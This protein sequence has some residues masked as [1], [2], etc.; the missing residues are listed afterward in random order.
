MQVRLLVMIP[1]A[2]TLAACP[3][4][5]EEE[6]TP[7]TLGEASQAVEESSL[8]SQAAAI[9]TNTVEITT[10]FTL[11][12]A[13]EEA[14]A[15][16]KTFIESQLPCAEITL[17]KAKLTVQYGKK[18]G[19]CTYRGQTYSGT[20]SVEVRKTAPGEVEVSHAWVDVS[21]QRVKVNGAA[22]VT[23]SA[24]DKSRRVVH[25]LTWTRLLDGRQGKGTG[26][27]TQRP[28]EGGV[29]EGIKVDGVRGWEGAR[30]KW[31]LAIRGVE[32]RWVDPMPQAGS[33]TLVAPSGRAMT[34][35]FTRLDADT[36][37]AQVASGQRSFTFKV[38]AAGDVGGGS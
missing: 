17:E 27:R 10:S 1:L 28:L 11:G 13:V 26:D 19:Q 34:M 31:D 37:Q 38:N 7:M 23:W 30:G 22:T 6:E 35:T 21:N 18:P 24:A 16:I 33:Y 5:Q 20:H 14:A 2:L 36:I 4:K 8:D 29:V 3:R 12:K 25:D 32:M 15:E 9:T